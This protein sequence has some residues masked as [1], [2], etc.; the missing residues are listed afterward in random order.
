MVRY[1]ETKQYKK[2]I[3]C[4][5]QILKK[6]P[7]HGETVCMKALILSYVNPED[8]KEAYDLVKQGLFFDLKSH[9]SWHVYGLMHRA[10]RNYHE[11]AKCYK[12]ALRIDPENQ[13]IL[14]DLSMLQLHQRDLEGYTESRRKLLSL[15]SSQR[16]NWMAYAVGEHMLGNYDVAKTLLDSYK[17]NFAAEVSEDADSKY[18]QS[19]LYLYQALLLEQGGE[20][21]EALDILEEHKKEI[22]DGTT[23]LESIARL[24]MSLGKLDKAE[25]ALKELIVDYNPE[26]ES[27]VLAWLSCVE[28]GKFSQFWPSITSKECCWPVNSGLLPKGGARVRGWL[29]KPE[30]RKVAAPVDIDLAPELNAGKKALHVK[31]GCKALYRPARE[32]SVEEE[33]DVLR[34]LDGL[35]AEV[36]KETGFASATITKCVLLFLTGERFEAR[37][38]EYVTKL[39]CKGV[40]S[41]QKL[42]RVFYKQSPSKQLSVDRIVRQC[43]AEGE[44]LIA[45]AEA[46]S[47]ASTAADV[48]KARQEISKLPPTYACFALLLAANHLDHI[49]SYDAA[50]AQ[51]DRGMEVSPTCIDLYVSASKILKHQER[52]D[53]AAEYMNKAREMDL[54]D[55]QLNTLSV[56]AQLRKGDID[57]ANSQMMMFAKENDTAKTSNLYDMQCMWWEIKTATLYES[58]E[59]YSMALKRFSDVLKQFEDI[60]DDQFDFATYCMRKMTLRTFVEFLKTEDNLEQHIYYREASAGMI[61]CYTKLMDKKAKDAAEAAKGRA[62]NEQ[63]KENESKLSSAERKRLK[64]QKKRKQ[65]D[66][67]Q[68]NTQDNSKKPEG[69]FGMKATGLT[70]EEE[71]A[72][73]DELVA[74]ADPLEKCTHICEVLS[75]KCGT[76]PETQ[77]LCFDVS[78]RRKQWLQALACLE[79]LKALGGSVAEQTMKLSELTKG[80]ELEGVTAKILKEELSALM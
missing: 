49:G 10:D 80:D 20:L 70:M 59:D 72:K 79:R 69:A 16:I 7:K 30:D 60:R 32:L 9:V 65:H 34:A 67:Q 43:L 62:N 41:T 48:P 3:K 39:L 36:K 51:I 38:K 19:E 27:Y 57:T 28:G 4:A 29:P 71:R 47:E 31:G 23:R 50:M 1:Y 64:H 46:R 8:K 68:N 76:W 33:Q 21:Q 26:Q 14:R 55:R 6:N 61:R 63:N 44:E 11:A 25:A 5:D 13:Q 40:P 52:F 56:K 24:S 17:K 37:L 66:Q 2:G 35:N 15:R 12:N 42:L 73:G 53:E 18:E 75:E 45:L 77:S 78:I 74:V 58:R 22:V 54:A